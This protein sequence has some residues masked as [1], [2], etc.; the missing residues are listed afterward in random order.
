MA[1]PRGWACALV[2]AAATAAGGAAEVA[3]RPVTVS[4]GNAAAMAAIADR[5][6]T[7]SWVGI[8]G[9]KSYDLAVWDLP[10]EEDGAPYRRIPLPEGSSSW[11]P[12]LADCLEPGRYA[13]TLRGI[14]E[15]GPSDWS[16][17]S[18]FEIPADPSLSE[19]RRALVLLERYLDRGPEREGAGPLPA[20]ASGA[21]AAAA[22]APRRRPP[23][24]AMYPLSSPTVGGG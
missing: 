18:L 3:S 7:F 2:S 5:C 19:I 1:S 14:W 12:P 21:D 6:P 23:Q 22:A 4:P 16:E 8:E 9:A 20:R 24:E 17:P 10:I 15:S 13:W 11:T